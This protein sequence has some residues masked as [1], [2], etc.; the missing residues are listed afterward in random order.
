MLFEKNK[1][2]KKLLKSD[3]KE[4][5]KHG[6]SIFPFDIYHNTN[7]H[8][9]ILQSHWHQEIEIIYQIKGKSIYHLDST[10]YPLKPGQAL[11]VNK[12]VIH[13]G[14]SVEMKTCE[15]YSVVFNLEL[16]CS[17][18][19]DENQINYIDPLLYNR[20]RFKPK[21]NREDS[22]SINLLNTL[23]KMIKIFNQKPD[24]YHL[25]IKSLLLQILY[26]YYTAGKF[27]EVKKE[28]ARKVDRLKKVLLFIHKNFDQ[29][30]TLADMASKINISKYYFC[31][32]FKEATGKSPIEYLNYYRISKA[33]EMLRSTDKQILNIA[34]EIGYNN[35]GY[36]VRQFKRYFQITPA[37]YRKKIGNLK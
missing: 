10:P 32:F 9:T 22:W 21:I 30:L 17:K 34:L 26:T 37:D 27:I 12:E 25:I 2:V 3:L 35:Y 33:G 20:V 36:F 19:E 24:A 5:V 6:S 16:L 8:K 15:F 11:F 1:R 14:E 7:R 23:E 31:R 13:G 28:T 29:E 18:N 4:K